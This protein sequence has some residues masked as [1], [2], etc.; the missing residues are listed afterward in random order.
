MKKAAEEITKSIGWDSGLEG[1]LRKQLEGIKD[2]HLNLRR[3]YAS[4]GLDFNIDV[5]SALQEAAQSVVI[6]SQ[7][8]VSQAKRL[9]LI[10]ISP[11]GIIAAY[12]DL[13]KRLS[14]LGLS[15]SDIDE[16]G[17]VNA[18]RKQAILGQ[19]EIVVTGA[20]AVGLANELEELA[21]AVEKWYAVMKSRGQNTP[22][23]IG[24][25]MLSNGLLSASHEGRVTLVPTG[26]RMYGRISRS[27]RI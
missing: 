9:D 18:E 21:A 5:P 1:Q 24:L 14:E 15:A 2:A 11:A 10:G 20:D 13:I 12:E 19:C 25:S 4:Q 6:N 7:R 3:H 16:R 23:G 22:P 27:E 26:I 17:E 8:E